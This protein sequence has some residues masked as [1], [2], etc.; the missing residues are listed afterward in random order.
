MLEDAKGHQDSSDCAVKSLLLETKRSLRTTGAKMDTL[1]I[2]LNQTKER[3]DKCATRI[4]AAEQTT[5]DL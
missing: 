4:D 3:L 2:R 1:T 5:S